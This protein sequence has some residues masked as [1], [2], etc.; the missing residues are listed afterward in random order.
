[1]TAGTQNKES[2]VTA[3]GH[4]TVCQNQRDPSKILLVLV[5]LAQ[6]NSAPG[7]LNRR[8]K[9]IVTIKC[10][11]MS[12]LDL[13]KLR[14]FDAAKTWKRSSK[15]SDEPST[16]SAICLP[17]SKMTCRESGASK[18][19]T[20]SPALKPPCSTCHQLEIYAVRNRLPGL[21]FLA[22]KSPC[23]ACVQT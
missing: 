5:G 18:S 20:V 6:P 13:F 21:V 1:M 23:H 7:Y 19:C 9:T 8:T 17:C 10:P 16:N 3:T 12:R 11:T 2:Q 4:V 15:H 22:H 14:C